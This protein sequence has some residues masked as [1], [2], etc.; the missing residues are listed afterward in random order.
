MP[1]R[2]FLGDRILE[3]EAYPF[4]RD[5]PALRVLDPH[6]GQLE[7]RRRLG[8]RVVPPAYVHGRFIDPDVAKA[9]KMVPPVDAYHYD[10]F[11]P[12]MLTSVP[13]PPPL[14]PREPG[15]R[16]RAEPGPAV[17]LQAVPGRAV[18]PRRRARHRAAARVPEQGPTSRRGATTSSGC[19]RT[20]RSRSGPA[21]TTSPTRTGPSRSTRTSTR[22]TSTSCRRRTRTSVSPRSWW[23]TARS[24]SPCRTSTPSR[25]RTPR[26]TTRAQNAVPPQRPG[27]AHPPVPHRHPRHRRG[28][29]GEAGETE[30]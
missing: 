24:S 29:R 15:T 23:S 4:E 2:T 18:R 14:P 27:A 10:V 26:L 7:A 16:G 5:D 3:L 19:S 11:R 17:G 22:S 20:S 30:S 25:R 28:A 8:V 6:Q 1:L 21:T 9:E 12:H 13:G